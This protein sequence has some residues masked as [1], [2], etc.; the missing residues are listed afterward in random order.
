MYLEA[1]IRENFNISPIEMQEQYQKTIFDK[2]NTSLNSEVNR[3]SE[4]LVSTKLNIQERLLKIQ[5]NSLNA[6][7]WPSLDEQTPKC[8]LTDVYANRLPAIEVKE[9]EL[10]KS[11][12]DYL[13]ASTCNVQLCN[14]I[15][16]VI[17]NS[18]GYVSEARTLYIKKECH[19]KSERSKLYDTLSQF[20]GQ[21]DMHIFEF[22]KRFDAIT[23]DF[24][25]ASE[26]VEFLYQRYLCTNIQEEV[27]QYKDDYSQLRK[28]LI[29]KYGSIK[30]IVNVLLYPI[31]NEGVPGR[32]D[33]VTVQVSYYRKLQ[34]A[35]HKINELL[36][37][38]GVPANQVQEYLFSNE[39]ITNLLL[40]LPRDAELDFIRQLQCLDKDDIRFQGKVAYKVLFNTVK[41]FYDM[42]DISARNKVI[43]QSSTKVKNNDSNDITRETDA[44][45][46]SNVSECLNCKDSN[47]DNM[48]CRHSHSINAPSKLDKLK[49]SKPVSKYKFPC[50]IAGHDHSLGE[51][52]EFFQMSPQQRIEHKRQFKFKYCILCLQSSDKCKFKNCSN[53]K[54]MPSI[55]KCSDCKAVSKHGDKQ[56]YS[57]LYCFTEKHCKPSNYD[58]IK[59]LE[60][61]IPSF[62]QN[63]YNRCINIACYCQ[64]MNTVH[65][66]ME[67]C[68]EYKTS[69]KSR[70]S[71]YT[72]SPG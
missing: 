10:C 45:L 65:S 44:D 43:S 66:A 3:Q 62:K 9:L 67:T 20:T 57:I 15:A 30:N 31:S 28:M 51:C 50:I 35:F 23:Q 38:P 69:C 55:L 16:I 4:F 5:M 32:E 1:N 14:D 27:I 8:T 36:T 63:Q 33:N 39:F 13:C 56:V 59:A 48:D 49:I 17:E 12:K 29:L 72:T 7:L 61:Y 70:S 11:L 60:E 37:F 68:V 26:K 46:K 6:L 25:I 22:L 41:Q 18:A 2:H 34:Y 21:S 42:F 64:P 71:N 58:I 40:Y 54:A 52:E 19:M 24:D 47:S 53:V